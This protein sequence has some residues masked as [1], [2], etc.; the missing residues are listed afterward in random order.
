M[1]WHVPEDRILPVAPRERRLGIAVLGCGDIANNAHLPAYRAYGFDVRACYD[2]CKEKSTATAEAFGI[3]ACA[4]LDEI[5]ARDDIQIID[6]AF[7]MEGRV[8]TVQKAALAGKHVLIQKPVSHELST[9]QEM[10]DIARNGGIK[11]QVN[12]QARWAPQFRIAKEWLDRGAIGRLNY[13]QLTVRG[14][15]DDPNSWYVRQQNMTLVDHGIHYFDLLRHLAG[16]DARSVA[17]MHASVPGQAHISPVIYSAVIDFGDGL[18]AC[19]AFNNK[20]ELQEPWELL[21]RLDGEEG[22]I[23]C[24]FS[25]ARLRRKDGTDLCE[26]PQRAWFPDAFAG[27]MADLMD[28]VADGRESTCSLEHNLGTLRLVLGALESA[29]QGQVVRL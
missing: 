10:A 8:E 5:L 20:V 23:E 18:T 22:S 12:Q 21:L 14:W 3:E 11:I 7:H 27:P 2:I 17:A 29:E 25:V 16:R 26:A 9:A 4:G 1:D 13:L 19:H 28:A 6:I 15:Q 24:S